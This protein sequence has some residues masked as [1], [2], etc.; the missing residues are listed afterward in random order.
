MKKLSQ[1]LLIVLTAVFTIASV[2]K[3]YSENFDNGVYAYSS[4]PETIYLGSIPFF[5]W[6]ELTVC[7]FA[8]PEINP[9]EECAGD[10]EIVCA[11]YIMNHTILAIYSKAMP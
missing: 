3:S 2:P 1:S 11:A 4:Y 6:P 9:S 7:D 10:C 5:Y 8:G